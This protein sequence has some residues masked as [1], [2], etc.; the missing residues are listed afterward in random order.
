MQKIRYWLIK[1]LGCVPK[2]LVLPPC[3][4]KHEEIIMFET[5]E[6]FT[7]LMLEQFPVNN[8]NSEILK[9]KLIRKLLSEIRASGM[10]VLESKE[11]TPYSIVAKAKI[12]VVKPKV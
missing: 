8:Y 1:K 4:L 9:E 5:T 12:G 6:V 3:G 7:D 2:E 10:I 11:N